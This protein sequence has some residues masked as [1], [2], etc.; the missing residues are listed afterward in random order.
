M[1]AA[2]YLLHLMAAA[3]GLSAE[4]INCD[5]FQPLSPDLLGYST[6]LLNLYGSD[7]SNKINIVS[8]FF[9]IF[10]FCSAK[11]ARVLKVQ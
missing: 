9:A 6:D 1:T 7:A 5:S 2:F 3:A 8:L 10:H 4:V 11:V